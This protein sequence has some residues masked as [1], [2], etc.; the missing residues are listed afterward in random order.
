[1]MQRTTGIR[2]FEAVVDG[3][4]DRAFLPF[5]V[6][7]RVTEVIVFLERRDVDLGERRKLFAGKGAFGFL[8][9]PLESIGREHVVEG[10]RVTDTG[11]QSIRRVDE[12]ALHGDPD[13][14]MGER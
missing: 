3:I 2:V 9:N 11:D 14:R 8:L 6:D 7:P 13:V 5:A 10:P 12:F 1:E 4:A